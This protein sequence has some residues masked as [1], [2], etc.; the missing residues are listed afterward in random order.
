[1]YMQA[2]E[3]DLEDVPRCPAMTSA[4]VLTS[5]GVPLGRGY[6]PTPT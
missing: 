6:S 5:V 3:K 4:L 2:A 1:M